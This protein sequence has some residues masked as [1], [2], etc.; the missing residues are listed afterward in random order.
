MNDVE[1]ELKERWDIAGFCDQMWAL[2]EEAPKG[3]DY[4]RQSVKDTATRCY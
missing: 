1:E 4:L 3:T 2:L